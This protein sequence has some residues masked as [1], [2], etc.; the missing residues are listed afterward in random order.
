MLSAGNRACVVSGKVSLAAKDHIVR[1]GEV[2]AWPWIRMSVLNYWWWQVGSFLNM[3]ARFA[4][5][6]Y[7]VRPHEVG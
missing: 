4:A 3:H 2:R 5:M 1:M 7:V 6:S